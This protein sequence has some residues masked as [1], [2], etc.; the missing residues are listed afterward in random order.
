MNVLQINWSKTQRKSVRCHLQEQGGRYYSALL[1]HKSY[2]GTFNPLHKTVNESR[3]SSVFIAERCLRMGEH[4]ARTAS[5]FLSLQ[6]AGHPDAR[7]GK[8]VDRKEVCGWYEF[9]HFNI[10]GNP[11]HSKT[12]PSWEYF[13]VQRSLT[14]INVLPLLGS[15]S[16]TWLFY[17]TWLGRAAQHSHF[18]IV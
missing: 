5:L 18:P 8:A 17:R 16:P 1:L 14:S 9:N 10:T 7:G 6:R 15:K 13:S 12:S 3:P 11:S 2:S 4:P